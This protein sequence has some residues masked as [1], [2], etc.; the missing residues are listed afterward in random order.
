MRIVLCNLPAPG[1]TQNTDTPDYVAHDFSVYPPLGL[2]YISA[3]IDRRH[4]I[5]L[6]DTN[7]RRLNIQETVEEIIKF[8]PDLVEFSV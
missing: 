7:S 4:P 1:R 8:E 3:N 2:L 6:I 5:K